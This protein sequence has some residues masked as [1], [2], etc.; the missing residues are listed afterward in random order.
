MPAASRCGLFRP[1]GDGRGLALLAA[2]ELVAELLALLQI[3]H[4]GL[5]DGRDVDEHVLRAVIGL[6]EAIALLCVE[7]LH[8]SG[9]H[10]KPFKSQL[11]GTRGSSVGSTVGISG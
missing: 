11:A 7:P 2:L 1:K 6:D 3:A 9:S 5:L 8:G 4:P 10:S